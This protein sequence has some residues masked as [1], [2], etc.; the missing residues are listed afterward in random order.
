[1]F[2][3]WFETVY[4]PADVD[5]RM[6][7]NAALPATRQNLTQR[8]PPRLADEWLTVEEAEELRPAINLAEEVPGG[9]PQGKCEDALMPPNS[10]NG[11][12]P[13]SSKGATS[14]SGSIQLQG[15]Q[16]TPLREPAVDLPGRDSYDPKGAPL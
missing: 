15:E 5:P 3:D 9:Q 11:N 7:R 14:R 13:S 8:T 2:D 10:D 6:G 12:P 1:V 4:S 16:P